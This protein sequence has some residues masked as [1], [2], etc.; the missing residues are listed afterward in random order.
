V[1][2]YSDDDPDRAASTA[3]DGAEWLATGIVRESITE[4]KLLGPSPAFILKLRG[5]YRWQITLKGQ[6]LSRVAH[7][8]PK[9]RGWSYDVDPV[10]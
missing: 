2:T 5:S 6:A 7:L 10:M 9:G 8:A 4:V 1:L 3:R